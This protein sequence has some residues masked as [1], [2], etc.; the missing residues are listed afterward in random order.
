MTTY[1]RSAL[2]H[3][4]RWLRN[5]QPEN[6]DG[7][8]I[9]RRE[10]S[11][12]SVALTG[13]NHIF[14]MVGSDRLMHFAVNVLRIDPV[15]FGAVMAGTVFFDGF[16]D[17][18]AGAIV[19]NHR[20][21][22]GRKLLPWL[23]FTSPLIAIF[24]FLLFTNVGLPPALALI[25]T[26]AMFLMW[27]VAYS[28]HDAALWGMTAAIHPN[29]RQS[30]RTVQWADIGVF[31]GGLLPGLTLP[32]LGGGGAFGLNQQQ[33]YFIFA[34]FLC[35]GGGFMTLFALQMK[36]RVRSVP[37]PKVAGQTN[38]KQALRGI[39]SNVSRLRY[40][41]V[42]LLFFAVRMFESITPNVSD[43]FM[44]Q[45]MARY[46]NVPLVGEIHP[47]AMLMIFTIVFGFPGA[48]LKPFALKIADR[49][50]SMKKI[51]IIGR[52]TAI[53]AQIIGFFVGVATWQAMLIVCLLEG[54]SHLPNSLFNIAQRSMLSD[55]VDY[56]EWK[57][58]H[59]TEAMTMSIRNLMSKTGAALRRFIMGYTLRWL[60]H[61]PDAPALR[62]PQ[63]AHFQQWIW[64]VFRLGPAI[65]LV[66]SLIPL[67]MVN[68][69]DELRLQVEADLAARH[70]LLRDDASDAE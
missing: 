68:Y 21:K 26:V 54:I 34:L 6:P 33:V 59:R 51:L 47:T 16:N 2:R 44:Y 37:A 12:L 42:L 64:P 60:Q 8:D 46:T 7:D 4:L 30:A 58:G 66:L 28:L 1:Q 14:S 10:L 50:G 25:Y 67:L 52:V 23:K 13:Q 27:D 24:S 49:V 9:P 48:A 39:L 53:V 36:E 63:N 20:F 45:D 40:N 65:G 32:M 57:T 15:H 41:H 29:S 18:A 61:N 56:V 35:L 17:L 11:S 3:P 43:M 55:S 5:S 70:A 62:Q 69:P 38:A 22:D 19:D 31:L